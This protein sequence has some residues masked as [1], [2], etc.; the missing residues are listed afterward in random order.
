MTA[1]TGR[2]RYTIRAAAALD[3]EEVRYFCIA[4]AEDEDGAEFG[5]TFTIPLDELTEQGRNL[6]QDT[7]SVSDSFGRTVYGAVAGLER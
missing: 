7:Y 6:S 2:T 5:L 4:L 1:N 3:L